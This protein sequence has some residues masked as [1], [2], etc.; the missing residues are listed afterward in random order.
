MFTVGKRWALARG[1]ELC[2]YSLVF[3]FLNLNGM[4]SIDGEYLPIMAVFAS[5]RIH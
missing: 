5:P 3:D 2:L 1:S 4:V